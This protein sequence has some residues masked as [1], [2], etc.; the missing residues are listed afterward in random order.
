MHNEHIIKFVGL[1]AEL[2]NDVVISNSH[3]ARIMVIAKL[4]P[5]LP[6]F[7]T[8]FPAPKIIYWHLFVAL[9]SQNILFDLIAVYVSQH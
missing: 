6:S 8:R 4:Y 2:G 3:V 9:L 1:M 5:V 7:N